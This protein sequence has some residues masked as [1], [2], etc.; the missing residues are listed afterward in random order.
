M[1]AS[2]KPVAT[3]GAFRPGRGKQHRDVIPA[4]G[5]TGGED[6]A[7]GGFPEH[8]LQRL[9]T[10]TPE[11]CGQTYPIKMHIESECSGGRI[12]GQPALLAAHLWKRQTPPAQLGGNRHEQVSGESK[13]PERFS[14]KVILP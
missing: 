2:V 1:L 4:L 10:G 3:F 14:E 9:V 13:V 12:I 8:P 7:G 5:M 6:F 11:F